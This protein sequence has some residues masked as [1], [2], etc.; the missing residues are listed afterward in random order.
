MVNAI[1]VSIMYFRSGME[2]DRQAEKAFN[3]EL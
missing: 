2:R 1:R 3:I